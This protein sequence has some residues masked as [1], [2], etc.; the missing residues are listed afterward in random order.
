MP[1]LWEGGVP[2]RSSRTASSA[3]TDRPPDAR[4]LPA[5]PTS[6]LQ[7]PSC[8]NSRR[9][10]LYRQRVW[11]THQKP[12]AGWDWP[13]RVSPSPPPQRMMSFYAVINISMLAGSYPPIYF[14]DMNWPSQIPV[15]AS[16]HVHPI[17][18]IDRGQQSRRR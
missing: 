14:V 3:S 11:R 6:C 12:T 7:K 2:R 17:D 1:M 13:D 10:I 9:E 8:R 4:R 16:G 18:R 5:A 15:L